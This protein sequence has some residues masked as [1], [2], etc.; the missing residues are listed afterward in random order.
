MQRYFCPA[1]KAAGLPRIR[2]HDLRHTNASIRLEQ[3][4]NIKYISTQLGHANPTIT[5]NTYSHLIKSRDPDAA[6]RL[7]SAIF[8]ATGHKMVTNADFGDEKRATEYT[9]TL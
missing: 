8:S 3:G 1:L 2:F 9:A 4:Q 5:L 6:E 7:E